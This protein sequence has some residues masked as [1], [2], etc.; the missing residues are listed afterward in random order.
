MFG[1]NDEKYLKRLIYNNQV[2]LFLGS[3]FSRDSKNKLG[4]HVNIVI[5]DKK[6]TIELN[7][8]LLIFNTIINKNIQKINSTITIELEKQKDN[9]SHHEP[10]ICIFNWKIVNI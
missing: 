10:H 9:K 7:N 5:N 6:I 3:G 2:V 4:I 1:I 8:V